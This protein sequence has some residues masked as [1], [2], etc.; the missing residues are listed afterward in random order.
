[1]F[2]YKA[3]DGTADSNVATVA[4]RVHAV[5]DTPT[6]AGSSPSTNEDTPVTVHLS[7][8]DVE[9][10]AAQLHFTIT[11]APSH[12]TLTDG[13]GNAVGVGSTFTGPTALTYPPDANYNGSDSFTYQAND[14]TA[15]S[16]V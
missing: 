15:D 1:S 3:N 6:A 5:N 9:T 13:N 7:G 10:P 14:G 16:N 8:S 11:Q 12:G 4:S 2:T